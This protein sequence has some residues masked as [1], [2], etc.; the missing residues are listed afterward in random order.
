MLI[1]ILIAVSYLLACFGVASA[2]ENKKVTAQTTFHIAVIFT[3]LIALLVVVFSPKKQ[4]VKLKL[5]HCKRCGFE[6]SE[7]HATCPACAKEGIN[8]FVNEKIK[9]TVSLK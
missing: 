3:P 2:A 6:F 9:Q 5:F 1:P 4:A 7:R 8:I